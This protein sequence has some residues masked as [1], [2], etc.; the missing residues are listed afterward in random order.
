MWV[1]RI[2]RKIAA[3]EQRQAE[4]VRARRLRPA[5]P[6][7][8]A[9]FGGGFEALPRALDLKVKLTVDTPDGVVVTLGS[10]KVAVG[11]RMLSGE[12]ARQRPVLRNGVPG[13]MSWR[14]DGPLSV[15]ASPSSKPGLLPC[16]SSSTRSTLVD[17]TAR[18]CLSRLVRASPHRCRPWQTGAGC[19]KV[20]DAS[21]SAPYTRGRRLSILAAASRK[22]PPLQPTA[23]SKRSRS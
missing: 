20:E 9:S 2:D 18:P 11:A 14:P 19:D 21:W 4:E 7:W 12:V 8:V 10:T 22:S 15:I 1:G 13:H 3:V 5:P 17:P 6:D 23:G 16:T